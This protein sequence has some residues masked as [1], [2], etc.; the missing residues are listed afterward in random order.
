MS[1]PRTVIAALSFS[2]VAF[3]GLVTREYYTDEAIVPTKNDRPTVGFGSTFREDGSPVE[4]GDRIDPVRAVKR[5]VSHI[6]KDERGLKR[7]LEG[8]ELS[9]VEYDVLVDFSYQYGVK[10]ACESS[11]ARHVK[12][13]NYEA[14]CHAYTLY[15]YSG[16]YDCSTLINGAPNKRCYGVWTGSLERRDKCLAAQ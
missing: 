16:G 10:K 15:K 11:M 1:P 9:Q 4:M 12:A 6:A 3:A 2:A 13:G 14:A 7:C 5:S 8:V